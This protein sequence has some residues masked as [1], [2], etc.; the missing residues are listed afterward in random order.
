MI[1]KALVVFAHP[2]NKSYCASFRDLTLRKLNTMGF[3]TFE[4]DLYKMKFNPV[5]NLMDVGI[6]K[7][8][9]GIII[10]EELK[11]TV[12]NKKLDHDVQSELEKVLAANYLIF[13]APM[14][15]GSFPAILKG[16]LEKVF[17]RGI[18]CDL[19]ND[20]YKG[21]Y[22]RGKKCMIVTATGYSKEFYAKEGKGAGGQTIEENYWHI[23]LHS[24][25]FCGME[26]L[27]IYACYGM[28]FA[29]EK[30]RKQY[31]V[32]YEKVLEN[33]ENLK[34]YHIPLLH[35]N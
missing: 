8:K 25:A 32:D 9:E 30:L 13:I 17:V 16:W 19:P 33:I 3:Q 15:F 22:L 28:D 5:L 12:E 20:I 24:F 2:N 1:K 35:E 23:I 27:P 14:W 21:G 18:V 6:N 26:T 10:T 31:L 4:S 7:S 34:P 11:R 29:D